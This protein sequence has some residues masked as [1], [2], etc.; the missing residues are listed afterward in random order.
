M[1]L[2]RQ[3]ARLPLGVL[4]RVSD[5]VCFVLYRVA[6]YRRAVVRDNL[7][8]AF[9]DASER[10]IREWERG[11]YTHLCDVFVEAFKLLDIS[12]EEVERRIEIR[13]AA[14]VDESV[15]A[16]RSV[17]LMLGHYGNW[18]WVPSI[19]RKFTSGVHGCQIYHPLRNAFADRFMLALRSRFGSESIPMAHA[20]R[21][22]LGVERS[23]QRF[24]CG[25][26]ADQRPLGRALRHWTDFMGIDSPYVVGG[27]SIGDHV[28]ASFLYVDVEKLSRGH[29]RLTFMPIHPP[30]GDTGEYPV[31]REYLRMLETTIR[32]NPRYWLW[33]HRRWSR[34]R[35]RENF[36][37]FAD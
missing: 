17:V 25:F 30:E 18:E 29:Y 3:V 10:Q 31:T 35:T 37:L 1:W 33:S 13:G 9:P 26:I 27:E 8:R 21:R 20:V 7:H 32:R 36:G 6:G 16:G 15:A 19:M 4:Y 5:V 11:F 12:D 22:L 34:K 28:G 23:G 24:V 2:L 14:L